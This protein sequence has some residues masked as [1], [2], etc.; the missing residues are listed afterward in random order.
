MA[1]WVAGNQPERR[2]RSGRARHNP[3][4]FHGEYDFVYLPIDFRTASLTGFAFVNLTSRDAAQRFFAHFHRFGRWSVRT[5][6]L[7]NVSWARGEQQGLS[8]NVERYR[9][10]SVMHSS[11]SEDLGGEY[12]GA[13]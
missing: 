4:G 5:R 1:T 10:S 6:K 2:L 9:N 11:V 7:C 12:E 3:Q 13:S 8:A